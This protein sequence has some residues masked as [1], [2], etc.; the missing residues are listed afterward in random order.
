MMKLCYL[1][2]AFT[3]LATLGL[4]AQD[5]GI[6]NKCS[7]Y[8]GRDDKTGTLVSYPRGEEHLNGGHTLTWQT[9]LHCSYTG[10]PNQKRLLDGNYPCWTVATVGFPVFSV[11]ESGGVWNIWQPIP[12]WQNKPAW[13]AVG[14]GGNGFPGTG[15]PG[16]RWSNGVLNNAA[17]ESI[18][19]AASITRCGI[20]DSGCFADTW[21]YDN[22]TGTLVVFHNY[23]ATGRTLYSWGGQINY[24]DVCPAHEAKTNQQ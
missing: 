16:V 14:I 13:H 17:A 4:V 3:L 23:G 12:G 19:A 22:G 15:K 9:H 1:L 2:F 21:Q 18:S 6:L 11:T 5:G 7:D 24:T 20:G 10:D 8:N